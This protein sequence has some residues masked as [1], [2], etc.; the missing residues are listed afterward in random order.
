M[1]SGGC[2]KTPTQLADALSKWRP[3]VY[4]FGGDVN[5]SQACFWS[6]RCKYK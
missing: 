6:K 1:L 3:N 2:M 5:M 4:V